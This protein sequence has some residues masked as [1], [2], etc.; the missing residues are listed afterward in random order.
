MLKARDRETK[1]LVSLATRLRLT[2]QARYTP[3]A[4]GTAGRQHVAGPRPWDDDPAARYF[5]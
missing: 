5:D 2:N 3:Q 1:Q 4:A